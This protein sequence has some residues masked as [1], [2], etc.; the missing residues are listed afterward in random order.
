MRTRTK[1]NL[2]ELH[3]VL[4]PREGGERGRKSEPRGKNLPHKNFLLV[5]ASL[6]SIIALHAVI[7]WEDPVHLQVGLDPS[8]AYGIEDAGSVERSFIGVAIGRSPTIGFMPPNLGRMLSD[9]LCLTRAG[10]HSKA[11]G[12]LSGCKF[13]PMI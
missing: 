6:L 9:V 5:V 11:F 2:E 13:F 12:H 1:L 10:G 7:D 3:P 8:E 4:S